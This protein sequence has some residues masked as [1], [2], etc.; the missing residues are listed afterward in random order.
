LNVCPFSSDGPDED[1][2]ATDCGLVGDYVPRLG[3]VFSAFAGFVREGGH[4]QHGSSG[5]LTT[6]LLEELLTLGHIDGVVHVREANSGG[7]S[8]VLF[9]YEISRSPEEIRKGAKSRYYPVEM[10]TVLREVRN[11]PGRYALVGLPCFIK[12]ARRLSAVDP[13]LKSRIAFYV[14]IFCGHLKSSRFAEA[15]ALECGIYP[16]EILSVDFR[17]KNAA[18]SAPDYDVLVSAMRDGK[19]LVALKPNRECF[20]SNWGQGFFK[21]KACDFCDD[22][23]AETA[24]ISFGDAWLPEY[25]TDWQGTNVVLVRNLAIHEVM[26]RAFESGHIFLEDLTPGRVVQSQAGA[27]RHRGDGLAYRLHLADQAGQWRPV[28][29]VSASANHISRR[30]RQVYAMRMVL[31]SES[32]RAFQKAAQAA[33]FQC[34]RDTMQ[35]LVDAY[36]SAVRRPLPLRLAGRMKRLLLAAKNLFH[37]RTN[38]KRV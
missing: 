16:H 32:H 9:H 29:R 24:D 38:A 14:G 10:S 21:L 13:L 27:F 25:S 30:A 17:Q 5:G 28:K 11:R 36:E 15:Y 31:A 19:P 8:D 33:N 26:Q 23:V 4:R 2:L 3:F 22:V 34:F 12:A 20:S 6:W 35:P 7:G 1:K 18:R 37:S